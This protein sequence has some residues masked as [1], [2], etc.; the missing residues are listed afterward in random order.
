M[1]SSNSARSY[2]GHQNPSRNSWPT[3]CAYC[4]TFSGQ[5]NQDMLYEFTCKPIFRRDKERTWYRNN[6]AKLC[7]FQAT[8][9]EQVT[10]RFT[11]APTYLNP[12]AEL[13]KSPIC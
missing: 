1:K 13:K 9:K 11:S 8:R 5:L 4:V 2:M 7:D 12:P 3:T 10:D 6:L